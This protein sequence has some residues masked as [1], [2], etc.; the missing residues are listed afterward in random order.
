[1]RRLWRS[2]A[3][4]LRCVRF[5][6]CADR[7][8]AVVLSVYPARYP[9]I[10]APVSRVC[11]VWYPVIYAGRAF[12]LEYRGMYPSFIALKNPPIMAGVF[13]PVPSVVV[14]YIPD[15]CAGR[16]F[17]SRRIPWPASL[18]AGRGRCRFYIFLRIP[19]YKKKRAVVGLFA[20]FSHLCI[21]YNYIITIS[22]FCQLHM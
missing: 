15:H 17:R 18:H 21:I 14:S 20:D 9:L 7:S 10:Y 6:L 13:L 3:F 5:T 8:P 2:F 22:S 16:L 19:F 4:P 1:M 11:S 12:R